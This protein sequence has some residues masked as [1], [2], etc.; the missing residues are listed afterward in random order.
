MKIVDS[1]DVSVDEW[2]RVADAC[3]YATFFHTPHWYDAFRRIDPDA[4]VATRAIR[5]EDGKSAVL[6]LLQHRRYGG[7]VR[8]YETAPAGCYGGWISGDDL[9]KEHVEALGDLITGR[10]GDVYW[11]IN[12]FDP[13][14]KALSA[15]RTTADSTEVLFLGQF[16]DEEA[17]RA[18]YRHSVRKQIN[19]GTRFGLRVRPARDWSDWEAYYAIYV[20]SLERWGS[21]A[22]SYYPIEFFRGLFDSRTEATRLW[23]VTSEETIVGGNLNF[24]QGIHCVEW[25]AVFLTEYFR[26]GSRN[27]LVH[28]L[29]LDAKNRGFAV[30][31]FNPSGTNEGT[32]EF[33]R[34]FGTECVPADIIARR[35]LSAARSVLKRAATLFRPGEAR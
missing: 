25:H 11:R 31:D 21:A 4:R 9:G 23:L 20:K 12:P 3:D 2:Q 34:N 19:K 24:Y 26:H 16:S 18:H 22:S 5:F 8:M 28:N 29:I 14:A 30:Y 6:P 33:K 27:F 13:A 35:R 10:L 32:R 7:L 17:L 1:Q 15:H